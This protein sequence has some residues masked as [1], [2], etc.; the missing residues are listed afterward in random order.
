MSH[1]YEPFL[2]GRSLTL[3]S[4]RE[5][6]AFGAFHQR[7]TQGGTEVNFGTIIASGHNSASGKAKDSNSFPCFS[8][9]VT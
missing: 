5:I 7:S 3:I 8:T 6:S 2:S 9:Q 4:L 1:C